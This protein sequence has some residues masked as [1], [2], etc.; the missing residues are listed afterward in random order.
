MIR[1]NVSVPFAL[2]LTLDKRGKL[3][4]LRKAGNEVASKARSLIRRAQG[5]GRTYYGGGGSKWRPK[6]H[7]KYQASAPGQPPVNVTG[8]LA[9]SI[10]VRPF[11]SGDGVAVRDS[12]F[13]ALF[14]EAGASGGQGSGRK[15]VKGKRNKRS[16]KVGSRVLAPRPF[17]SAALSGAD[18]RALGARIEEALLRGIALRKAGR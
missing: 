15:G 10:K 17:L 6:F 9:K 18:E 2:R 8:T 16:G 12:A 13:Y 14:L 1:L 11:P 7:G 5:G 3:A 4:V